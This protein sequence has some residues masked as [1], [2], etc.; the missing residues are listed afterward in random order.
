MKTSVELNLLGKRL[1][2]QFRPESEWFLVHAGQ[3]WEVQDDWLVR[4]HVTPRLTMLV[5]LLV[6]GKTKNIPIPEESLTGEWRTIVKSGDNEQVIE[7]N[8]RT[9]ENPARCMMDRWAGERGLK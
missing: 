3:D 4:V 8:F 9:H 5:T 2:V 7:D 6:Q 1:K